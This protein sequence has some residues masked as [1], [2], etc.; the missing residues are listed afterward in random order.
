MQRPNRAGKTV[1]NPTLRMMFDYYKSVMAIYA[2][3][4]IEV[5]LIQFDMG[6]TLLVYWAMSIR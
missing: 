4:R 1:K 6:I 2:G 3:G 5:S